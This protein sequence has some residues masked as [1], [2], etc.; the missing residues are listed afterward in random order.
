MYQWWGTRCEHSILQW[1]E[2]HVYFPFSL[3]A[4][5]L[6]ESKLYTLSYTI[7]CQQILTTVSAKTNWNHLAQ[8]FTRSCFASS[9][10]TPPPTKD[11]DRITFDSTVYFSPPRH[12][13]VGFSYIFHC[14]RAESSD[15]KPCCFIPPR[16]CPSELGPIRF[17]AFCRLPG[18][19]LNFT[20]GGTADL[21]WS[22]AFS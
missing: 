10:P 6:C 20:S 2:A 18:D 12:S 8:V 7:Y 11:I 14:W 13:V 19:G 17:W 9:A 15:V 5:S 1:Q 21:R 3:N 16:H 22:T 4:T